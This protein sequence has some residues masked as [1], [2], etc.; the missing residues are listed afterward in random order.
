[1]FDKD[2]QISSMLFDILRKIEAE[3][4]MLEKNSVYEAWH[5][6]VLHVGRLEVY[7]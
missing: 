1:M 4:Y 3:K 5:N 6:K 2:I 7:Y